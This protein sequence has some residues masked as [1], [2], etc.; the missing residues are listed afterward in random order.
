[1][2]RNSAGKL[3]LVVHGSASDALLDGCEA[4]RWPLATEVLRQTT[5]A[6]RRQVSDSPLMRF[7]RRRV[8]VP[9]AAT[10]SVRRRAGQLTPP[11]RMT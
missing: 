1:M 3:A 6:N 8:L 2:R 7:L 10:P 11:L 5:T 4:E 9:V